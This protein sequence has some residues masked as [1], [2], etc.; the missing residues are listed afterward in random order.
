MTG[1]LEDQKLP[2]A[3]RQVRLGSALVVV[4]IF[5]LWHV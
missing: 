4:D 5:G 3:D 1:N 2:D